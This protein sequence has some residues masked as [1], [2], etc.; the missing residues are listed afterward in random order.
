MPLS[1][2]PQLRAIAPCVSNSLGYLASATP[3]AA[4]GSVSL[5]GLQ[6]RWATKRSGGSTRNGRDS[7][8]KRLGVKKF[9]G[10]FAIPGNIIVRQRGTQF[11][12]GPNVGMG[13]D[14][15]LFALKPG[16]I[17]IYTAYKVKHRPSGFYAAK[18]LRFVQII[19]PDTHPRAATIDE[20]TG[21]LVIDYSQAVLENGAICK[22]KDSVRKLRKNGPA[23]DQS[24]EDFIPR[25]RR[26]ELVDQVV[27][28]ELKAE[29]W[30][31]RLGDNH[32]MVRE[33][34]A[35]LAVAQ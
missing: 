26:M 10:E 16:K 19:N 25:V 17:H 23:K 30:R 27:V 28:E 2:L 13:R 4:R 18:P 3:L 12:A 15:T 9:G 8:S 29:S 14:H 34:L 32:W 31:N 24:I 6:R 33:K 20:Q 11:H 21:D 1:L 22:S 5:F 7:E 35:A